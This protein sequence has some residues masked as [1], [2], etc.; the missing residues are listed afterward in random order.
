M[1]DSI[2]DLNCYS[3][4]SVFFCVR[5]FLYENVPQLKYHNSSVPLNVERHSEGDSRIELLSGLCYCTRV[6]ILSMSLYRVCCIGVFFMNLSRVLYWCIL[7]EPVLCVL[8]WCILYEPVS[9]VLYW[10]ILYEPVSCVVLVYS[11]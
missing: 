9:C 11:L 4:Y 5:M 7:Y 1:V 8:Y 6:S 2:S 10:C 3:I